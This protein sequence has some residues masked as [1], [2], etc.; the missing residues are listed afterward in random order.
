[1]NILQII[2][3]CVLHKKEIHTGLEQHEGRVNDEIFT[4]L[5]IYHFKSCSMQY[6]KH[7]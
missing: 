7:W 2:L 5:V 3:L 6:V 4:I 1:M